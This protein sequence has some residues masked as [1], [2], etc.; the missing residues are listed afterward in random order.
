[1]YFPKNKTIYVSDWVQLVLENMNQSDIK[2]IIRLLEYAVRSGCWDSIEES[3]TY[4]QEYLDD[5]F[6]GCIEE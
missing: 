2:E 5:P 1:M 3:I 4:L 6:D